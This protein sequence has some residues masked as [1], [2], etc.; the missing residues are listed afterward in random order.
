MPRIDTAAAPTVDEASFE[1]FVH[2][3]FTDLGAVMHAATVLIGE[4]VG[5]YEAMADTGWH[6]PEQLAEATGTHARY[7]REW[8]AAQAA[9]GYTDYDPA[10]GRFRLT[11]EQALALTSEDAPIFAPAGLQ[12]AAGIIADVDRLTEA[13]RRGRG[14]AYGE[15]HPNLT[16]G[17]LRFFRTNYLSHLTQYWL[18][19]LDGVE[20]RLRSGT[21]VADIGCGG[22][23][24]TIIMANAYPASRFHGFDSDEASIAIARKSAAEA[25]VAERCTF[26]VATAKEYPGTGYG[27]VTVFDALHD[28]G[29]P[30]GA[31]AHVRDTL[32]PD[33]TFMIVEP[34]AGDRLEDNLTPIGRIFYAASTTVCLPM[35]RAQ[36]V[37]AG[38]G[39]QA[40][41]TRLREVVIT[42]G[43]T[44][45]RRATQ[46]PFNL[47]LEA[48]P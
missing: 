8:L 40:G 5:L 44:R 18:P 7:V 39:A 38:L 35:S 4:R 26:E 32:A 16:D 3:F 48:R 21:D 25:G 31:V 17:T 13:F 29:D 46:T 37:D 20:D 41:E 10:S 24:S 34:F 12:A 30:I 14:I 45:F 15:H 22:G 1:A 19:A 28:M 42:G 27:L 36:E 9:S 47:I 6:T 33:G 23:A 43:F 11:P 2:R